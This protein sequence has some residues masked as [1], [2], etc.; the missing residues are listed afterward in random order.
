MDELACSQRDAHVRRPSTDGLEEHEITRLN[1]VTIELLSLVVLRTRFPG[2]ARPVLSE[3]PLYEATA[4]EPARR[5]GSAVPVRSTS[6]GHR[7]RDEIG[8][9][10]GVRAR[11]W[12]SVSAGE[13]L[14]PG[15]SAAARASGDDG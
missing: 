15:R 8:G 11:G 13:R 5:I 9:R 12:R 7:R 14:R 1:I 6:E 4:I 10:S 2:E 3:D